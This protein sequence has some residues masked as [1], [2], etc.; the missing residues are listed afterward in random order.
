M[1][2]AVGS[3]TLVAVMAAAAHITGGKWVGNG[4]FDD[5]ATMPAPRSSIPTGPILDSKS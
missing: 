4:L 2:M 5:G 3:G 1:A